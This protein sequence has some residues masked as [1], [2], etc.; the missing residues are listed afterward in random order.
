MVSNS[1]RKKNIGGGDELIRV[2]RL[3]G[4]RRTV[5]NQIVWPG[6]SNIKTLLS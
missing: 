2:V 5:K 4:V 1:K 3:D 6:A